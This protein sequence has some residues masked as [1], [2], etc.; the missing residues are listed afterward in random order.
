MRIATPFPRDPFTDR[1]FGASR[2]YPG[3]GAQ[4]ESETFTLK[5][6]AGGPPL[7]N[8]PLESPNLKLTLDA[9]T[10]R[11]VEGEM[12]VQ[13]RGWACEVGSA[14]PIVVSAV[15]WTATGETA[16]VATD[17]P[18]NRQG[19]NQAGIYSACQA[20]P[21]SAPAGAGLRFDFYLRPPVGRSWA[22]FA[23]VQFLHGDASSQVTPL[24]RPVPAPE[25]DDAEL[26]FAAAFDAWIDAA[27]ADPMWGYVA[28][29]DETPPATPS[30]PAMPRTDAPPAAPTRVSPPPPP[31]SPP[32]PP[33]PPPSPSSPALPADVP[34]LPPPPPG[35]P[36]RSPPPPRPPS[37]EQP[38][39]R[40]PA[41]P[42]PP[43]AVA[44][45][46]PP[47]PPPM[48]STAP[49]APSPPLQPS[50]TAA[51]QQVEVLA[52][53]GALGALLLVSLAICACRMA[54]AEKT[55]ERRAP[56]GLQRAQTAPELVE[57]SC[58]SDAGVCPT[59]CMPEASQGTDHGCKASLAFDAWHGGAL[60]RIRAH[61]RPRAYS[62]LEAE[63]TS[64]AAC[65]GQSRWSG[66]RSPAPRRSSPRSS[67][68]SS[69]S[70][71]GI[72]RA[73]AADGSAGGVL[74][75]ARL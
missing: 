49:T 31:H 37:P 48:A 18:S 38:P 24:G 19:G 30:P 33:P 66:A 61:S 75:T 34:Q 64:S 68:P 59:N 35:R 29:A 54:H 23:M 1:P 21:S 44:T 11:S 17:E 63:M 39:S 22:E 71:R 51:F 40:T 13:A 8:L 55:K 4:A 16:M 2:Y 27:R 74:H 14:A 50:T 7:A 15:A 12:L 9:M 5:C 3:V 57:D 10:L 70:Q 62:D 43:P 6:G 26:D 73:V 32:P 58:T 20:D 46:S 69:P 65:G 41:P 36:S 67:D 72:V 25:S 53:G 60:G 42:A 52:G 47:S 28:P 56:P 45:P